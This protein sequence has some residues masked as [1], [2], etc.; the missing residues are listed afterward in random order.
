M[1]AREMIEIIRDTWGVPRI[2]AE[3][4]LG[5][6][7][8]QGYA[9]A[10]DR[11]PTMMRAYRMAVGRMA[12][13]YGADWVEHDYQ[14]RVWKHEEIARV[15]FKKLNPFYQEAAKAFI[16]GVKQYMKEYPE[17]VPEHSLEL[18]PH[19]LLALA[20]SSAV[21]WVLEQA[22]SDFLGEWCWDA[23][24]DWGKIYFANQDKKLA[25]SNAWAVMPQ[26]TATNH[27]ITLLDPHVGWSDDELPW[28]GHL[29]GG[30]LHVYGFQWAGLPY[31]TIGHNEHISWTVTALGADTAD[32]YELTL[33]PDNTLQYLYDNE[34]RD[35]KRETITIR[36]QTEKGIE[37]L[38]RDALF[39][40]YGPVIQKKNDKA[41]AFKIAYRNDLVGHLE[42]YG[43]LNKAKN[44]ADFLQVLS[45][46]AFTPMNWM[47]GDVDGN[48]YYQRTGRVPIRPEGYD[49]TRSV[50][51]NT[52][53]TE[54]L[55]FHN[56]A[57]LV[58]V[59]NPPSGWMQNCNVSPKAMTT[60]NPM[61]EEN[62]P[63]H[64]FRSFRDG[65]WDTKDGS[66]SRGRRA[67]ELLASKEKM[68]LE[69][70]IAVANDTFL[71]GEKVWRE[72]L[73]TA[74]QMN[75]SDYPHLEEAINILQQWDGYAT[76]DSVGMT[77]F[78][79]W[80]RQLREQPQILSEAREHHFDLSPD[81]QKVFL[82]SLAKAVEQFNQWFG[83]IA[84]PWE[85]VYRA[86]H[87][88]ENWP[89]SGVAGL[90]FATLR[91]VNGS[92]PDRNG[93]YWVESG[94]VCT[95]L[96]MLEKNNVKSCSVIPFGQSEDAES[97]HYTDQGRFLFSEGKFKD[98]WFSRERLEEHT[99]SKKLLE[100]NVHLLDNP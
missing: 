58:Q 24:E 74:Y 75:S 80:W 30:E 32:V 2:Y 69:Q 7:Y 60:D 81:A 16:A 94:Q 45:L 20:R 1:V 97:P 27:V 13:V 88:S 36:V 96:V 89:V 31:M 99:E 11:L 22:W 66:N 78:R 83:R 48:I 19:Y 87:G 64:L 92:E 9:M 50:P 59:L 37:L 38:E 73:F 85:Q 39:S 90:E 15:R 6:I 100:F 82:N 52:S 3:T 55:G 62:Y 86:R 84:V 5:A 98:T 56:T 4:E 91:L 41:Y 12:E 18:S 21:W 46:K 44:L 25:G 29:H 71:H 33:N 28:E 8:G 93:V 54:W 68:T 95:T 77:L 65:R 17:K 40:H 51:G 10:E 35:L 43:Q 67:N 47:Y 76:K 63:E 34:W 53:K 23:K 14:Q 42:P 57:E 72:T 79:E 61:K 70:A 49:W 26:R